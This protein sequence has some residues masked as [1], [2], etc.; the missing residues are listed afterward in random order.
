MI[1]MP[2]L[3]FVR[4][5]A[6]ASLTIVA[7]HDDMTQ[8]MHKLARGD[9]PS[10]KPPSKGASAEEKEEEEQKNLVKEPKEEEEDEGE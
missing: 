8:M 4:S 2:G 6:E 3:S 5:A 1:D 7:P 10:L 9:L